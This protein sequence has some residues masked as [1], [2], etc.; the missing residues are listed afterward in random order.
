V[1]D[2][3]ACTE[4]LRLASITVELLPREPEARGLLA[5]L[6]LQD[7]RRATRS[8]ADG[9]LVL[10]PDQDRSRWDRGRIEAGTA[11]LARAQEVRRI[12]PYQLQAA[13]AAEHAT[14][15]TWEATDWNRIVTSYDELLA[16]T[17][18]PVVALN[19]AVAIGER[20]GPSA[21][22]PIVVAL[23]DHAGLARGH[24]LAATR[25][26]LLERSGRLEEA[27]AALEEA[28]AAAPAGAERDHL[29]R[30]LAHLRP[31]VAV[32]GRSEP[33]SPVP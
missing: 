14:A 19:R 25:G 30:R 6:L 7:S 12:G 24:R 3:D 27:V 18:S 13:I 2:A 28:A 31:T 15:P 17:D 33:S 16:L 21:A 22:L 10:L 32:H 4:A 29:A 1:L 23:A 5:L 11:Q 20:D 8:D 9:G 26:L